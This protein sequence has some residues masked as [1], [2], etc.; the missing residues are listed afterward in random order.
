MIT[1]EIIGSI[2]YLYNELLFYPE[3]IKE[4]IN[5]IKYTITL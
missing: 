1:T 4:Y 5:I 3:L 2:I